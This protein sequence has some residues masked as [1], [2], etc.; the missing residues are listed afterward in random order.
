LEKRG[1]LIGKSIDGSDH[2]PSTLGG[3]HMKQSFKRTRL[4]LS[5]IVV[6]LSVTAFVGTGLATAAT[7]HWASATP[8]QEITPG[9]T[10]PFTAATL[11]SIHITW[12]RAS[13]SVT[14]VC[15]KA[16]GSGNL[17]NP[18]GGGAA[19]LWGAS[20]EFQECAVNVAGCQL[21]HKSIPLKPLTGYAIGEN[22]V[23]E[24]ASGAVMSVL[25][26]NS[27]CTLGTSVTMTGDIEGLAA[28][29]KPGKFQVSESSSHLSVGGQKVGVETELSLAAPSGTPLMLVIDGSPGV[30]HWYLAGSEWIK[31]SSGE[32]MSY[33]SSGPVPLVIKTKIAGANVEISGCEG[34]A[35]GSLEN[36]VGG[37]AGTVSLVLT[38]EWAG[39]CHTNV[40]SCAVESTE[41]RKVSG[42]ATEVGV[43][44]AVEWSSTGTTVMV[45]HLSNA[46]GYTECTLGSSITVTGKLIAASQGNGRY[47]LALSELKVGAQNATV[48]GEFG[49]ETQLGKPV[50]LQP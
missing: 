6:A 41:G 31:L 20:L 40:K 15:N 22:V 2:D 30:S 37:G 50:R 45:F 25:E 10:Q 33:S 43:V 44:P 39:G 16:A 35:A 1:S 47:S 28:P 29:T 12:H 46:A 27:G 7:Q 36:P 48:S 21:I 9:S 4:T 5:L 19:T 42:H 11:G 18:V 26:F 17:Q 38:P 23:L 34:I 32:S 8:P 14:M 49:L 24:P 3:E 13:G